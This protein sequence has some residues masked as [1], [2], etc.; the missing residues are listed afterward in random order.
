MTGSEVVL[1]LDCGSTVTKAVVY[2]AHG[3]ALGS[4]SSPTR[5]SLPRPHWVERD[6][7]ELWRV[8]ADTIRGSLAD[9]DVPASAVRAVATTGHGD[10]LYLVDADGDPVRP[11]ILSLDSRA[12]ALVR[13][14]ES[15]GTLDRAMAATGQQPFVAAPAALLAWLDRHEPESIRATRWVVSCKDWVKFRLTGEAT[16]DLTEASE[17]FTNHETQ[18]YSDDALAVYGLEQLRDALP[19]ALG[20]GEVAGKVTDA[21]AQA[22]GLRAGTPVVA[23]VHDVDAAALGSGC[24]RPGELA[25]IAGT[26]S[27]N[28]VI[29]AEPVPDP[30]WFTRNFVDYGRWLHMAISPASATNLEWFVRHLC[31]DEVARAERAGESP[32]AFVDRVVRDVPDDPHDVLFL[33]FLFGSPQSRDSGAA[34]VGLRGWHDRAHALRAVLDGVVFNHRFHIDALRERFPVQRARLAGGGARAPYWAQLFADTLALTVEVA[35]ISEAGTL[36]AAAC[37]MVGAGWHRTITDAVDALDLPI[38]TYEP[39]TARGPRLDAAY[40]RYRAVVEALADIP[41]TAP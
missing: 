16:T 19:P 27:I 3:T 40:E 9:A 33:P 26:Y 39:D 7:E 28:E 10:G 18:R 8:S 24:V 12:V 15:D 2:D 38:R 5:H 11:G 23:G 17:S 37:A 29:A 20:S 25:V 34:F 32:F 22:C 41:G 31:P 1:G 30:R 36:G 4:A 35:E 13:E 6:M 14:W 21:A